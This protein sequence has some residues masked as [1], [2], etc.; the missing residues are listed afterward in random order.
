MAE[1]GRDGSQG[2]DSERTEGVGGESRTG[3][4][5]ADPS[6]KGEQGGHGS[7]L[8]LT[9]CLLEGKGNLLVII[10]EYKGGKKGKAGWL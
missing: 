10:T 5:G 6:R 7:R 2:A 3:C 1:E 4:T 8:F 9:K